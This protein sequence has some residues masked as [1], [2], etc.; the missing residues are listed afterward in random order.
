MKRHEIHKS[1][2]QF[3]SAAGNCGGKVV[4][5]LPTYNEKENIEPL[6][7][8]IQKVF[9]VMTHDMNILVVDD[10]SPDGTATV[11]RAI[12]E[13]FGNVQMISGQKNGLGFAY[14]RGMT[15][16]M[17]T[18][19]ADIIMEMDADF[20]HDPEDIPRLVAAIAEGADFSIGSRYVKGG[21]IPD[22]WGFIRR[23][24][25]KWGNIFARYVAGLYRVRD[26]TAGFRAIRAS[27]LRKINLA[28][29]KVQGYSFQI[30]LLHEAIVNGAAVRE[31]PV[32]F[33]DRLR[34]KSK[35]AVSDIIEFMINAWWIRLDS[36]KTFIKFAIVG[37]TGVG[38]NLGAFTLLVNAGLNK[39]IASPLAIELSII[40]NF[41]LNNYWTFS[42]RNKRDHIHLKGLK[43]NLVSL[44]SLGI[45][46][47]VF[48][49]LSLLFPATAPQI[50]QAVGIIPAMLV[51]Y[52]LNAYWTF[53][54]S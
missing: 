20:S 54:E 36:S 14:I 31:V 2:D 33:T 18:M 17:D 22:N 24:I 51:N 53:R 27:L 12:M 26:C 10:N 5:V 50:H 34:G 38:L 3:D 15:Y 28:D 41:I 30:A 40:S 32:V 29:L 45:S 9:T 47:S 7:T 43:F 13:K 48:V 23:M 19:S 52:F 46:Y 49:V 35:L 37:A 25:S 11:V 42:G 16:A 6:I 21:K 39:Y 8:A 1:S 44:F 4:I